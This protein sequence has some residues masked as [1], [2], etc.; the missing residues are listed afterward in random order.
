MVQVTSCLNA[1]NHRTKRRVDLSQP[2]YDGVDEART[3]DGSADR[4]ILEEHIDTDLD[5]DTDRSRPQF[6]GVHFWGPA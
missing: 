6:C 1:L 3:Y 2:A 4:Q 5:D